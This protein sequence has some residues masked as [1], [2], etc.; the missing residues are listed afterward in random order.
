MNRIFLS[1]CRL[2]IGSMAIGLAGLAS[3]APVSLNGNTY[4]SLAPLGPVPIPADN[5][6]SD[7]KIALGKVLFFDGRVGGDGSTSCATC[8]LPEQGWDVP[9]DIS[10][11]YPGTVHWRNS[12][13]I[14]NSAYYDKLFWAGGSN[15]LE[16]QA[17][18]AA[19][20]G[21]AGNGESDIME[22]RLAL[23]PEYVS[24]FNAVFGTTYP[25]ITDAWNAI[26]AYERT[27]VQTDTPVDKYFAGDKSALNATQQR[28]LTLFNE[29]AGCIA[30][31][32]GALATDQKYYNIGVPTNKRWEN[33]ALAQ[34][35]FRYELYAKG[36][37]EEMYRAYKGDPGVYFRGKIKSMKG[38]FRVPS[39]RYTKYTAPYMH[40]GT[41]ST[42]AEVIEFYN[43]GGV[44]ADGRTTYFPETKSTL[45]TP[46]GLTDSE[47]SD[48]LAFLLAFSG[49]KVSETRP[50][51]PPYAPM[52]TKA[53]LLEATK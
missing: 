43:K 28:G 51:L 31:H 10:I 49:E 12:Q 8:H 13:T 3:A 33:E 30:C 47:K 40:N 50:A 1:S 42:L 46:L 17:K 35:T 29:K 25:L 48:L 45:M 34:I 2:I 20:G 52:F 16:S 41:I 4:P 27:L 26:A 7:A 22:A 32:N 6:M 11:G 37:T 53:Q 38:K 18:S 24:A 36:S 15:S 9:T 19:T 39:L 23:I 14:I 44:A 21:V 5:P